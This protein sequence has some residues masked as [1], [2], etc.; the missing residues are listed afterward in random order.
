M[1]SNTSPILASEPE[2]VGAAFNPANKGKVVTTALEGNNGVYVIRVDNVSAT[3]VG[4]A[5]V[6]DQRKARYEQ[7]KMR[8]A[9][10]QQALMEAASI[11]DNR[12]KVY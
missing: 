7:Q 5:N 8:G 1:T 9:Y 2:V 6:A 3:A 11:K 4:D 12:G 10:P